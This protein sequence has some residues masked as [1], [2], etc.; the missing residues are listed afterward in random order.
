MAYVSPTSL[1]DQ[2]TMPE[3]PTVDIASNIS[4][5]AFAFRGYNLTN[6]GRTDELLAHDAYRR[7]MTEEL[8]RFG[9]LASDLLDRRINLKQRVE[10]Q[11]ESGLKNYAESLALIMAAE[12][13][14]M[15]MLTELHGIEFS[16]AKLALGYSLG[17][18]VAICCCGMFDVEEMAQVPLSMADDCAK[19]AEDVSMG[20]LF[21]RGPAIDEMDVQ[22]LCIQITAEGHGTIGISAV[23]SPNTLLLMGQQETVK[24]LKQIMHDLLPH[25]AHLRVKSDRWPP[26]HTPIVRQ[27]FIPDRTAVMLET[28]AGGLIPPCPPVLSLVTGEQ[29]YD[30]HHGRNVLRNWGDHPQRLWDCVY[31]T[32]AAGVE[33][34]VHVG[35]V[36]NV[37][38][39]TFHRLSDNVQEQTNCNSLSCLG[40]RAV[41]GLARRPWLSAILPERTA[42][43]RAPMVQHVI[44][45]DWLLENPPK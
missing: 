9:K 44:L 22:R 11:T 29:S 33:T 24:R 1:S 31:E 19:L 28:I 6:L 10:R 26:V 8:K 39:A 41:A 5:T 3:S 27:A 17:E 40:M 34:I 20:V 12:I 30:D 36:P 25:R 16:R 13:A 4:D 18:L 7:I 37:I 21:S 38:P 42:L 2:S 23:L 35:P 45:E 15:R 14:Q 43:L 32:L